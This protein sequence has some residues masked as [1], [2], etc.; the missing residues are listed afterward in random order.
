[1]KKHTMAL[2]VA[3]FGTAHVDSRRKTI[4]PLE[5]QIRAAFP[6]RSF[7]RCYTSPTVRRLMEQREGIHTDGPA[8][9]LKRIAADGVEEVLLFVTHVIPGIEYDCIARQVRDFQE[10]HPQVR[11][12]LTPPLLWEDGDYDAC[13]GI[14]LEEHGQFLK[15]NAEE[16]EASGKT[17]TDESGKTVAAEFGEW[18]E[19]KRK[20]EAKNALIFFGHGTQHA[21]DACYERLERALRRKWK[22]MSSASGKTEDEPGR[23]YVITVEGR[24]T[25]ADLIPEL[26]AGGVKKALLLPFLLT[27]GEHVMHDM[28][29]DEPN[30]AGSILRAAGIEA[31]PVKKGLGEYDRIRE[32]Y[33]RRWQ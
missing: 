20:A 33:V 15:V 22:A 14:L 19:K 21:A 30:S 5:E 11:I 2:L 8:E 25:A 26:K 6:E 24:R 9:A 4:A 13:A 18:P 23:I 32:Y 27:A 7:Y 16:A 10:A 31:I 1:M 29:G 12:R 3:S 17:A 28:A